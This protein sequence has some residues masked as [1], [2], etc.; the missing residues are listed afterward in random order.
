MSLLGSSSVKLSAGITIVLG[1]FLAGGTYANG[2]CAA[3]PS[4]ALRFRRVL[5]PEADLDQQVRGLLPLE[6]REF[7]AR[8]KEA[9]NASVPGGDVEARIDACQTAARLDNGVLRGNSTLSVVSQSSRRSA[10]LLSPWNVALESVAWNNGAGAGTQLGSAPDGRLLCFVERNSEL[11]ASW[12]RAGQT[13]DRGEL[14]FDLQWPSTTRHE[15]RLELPRGRTLHVDGGLVTQTPE[16]RG[17]AD[18]TA[19]SQWVVLSSGSQLSLRVA[20]ERN[21]PGQELPLL[22]KERTIYAVHSGS[23]EIQATFICDALQ[24]PLARTVLSLD[25]AMQLLDVRLGNESLPWSPLPAVAGRQRVAV[26]SAAAGIGETPIEVTGV[27]PWNS[28]NKAALP[29]IDVVGGA[30]Q[31]GQVSVAADDALQLQVEAVAGFRQTAFTPSAAGRSVDVWQFQKFVSDATIEIAASRGGAA[32]VEQSGTHLRLDATQVTAVYRAHLEF[33]GGPKFELEAAIPRDWIVDGVDITPSDILAD[34][35]LQARG[36]GPQTMRL[37][38][39]R[40]ATESRSLDIVVR[41]HRQRPPSGR[42]LPADLFQLVHWNDLRSARRLVACQV[43]D[44]ATQLSLASGS[45]IQRLDVAALS[46]GDLALFEAAPGPLLWEMDEA[47]Q[48]LR[49]ALVPMSPRFSASVLVRAEIDSRQI[50]ERITV[51][52]VPESS[53]I[54]RLQIRSSPAPAGAVVWRQVAEPSRE[55]AARRIDDPEA[56]TDEAIYEIS[57]PQPRATPFQLQAEITRDRH[58]ADRLTLASVVD[59][60]SQSSEIEIRAGGD[61]PLEID[62][63]GLRAVLP[64]EVSQSSGLPL[65]GIYRYE[66]GRAA[67]LYA[68]QSPANRSL[69]LAWIESLDLTSSWDSSGTGQH[70]AVYVAHGI[71][72]MRTSFQLPPGSSAV[73]A[74]VDGQSEGSLESSSV[75]GRYSLSLPAAGRTV[76]QLSYTTHDPPLGWSGWGSFSSPMPR[77]DLPV[78][79]TRWRVFTAPGIQLWSG[80]AAAAIAAENGNPSASFAG[81]GWHRYEVQPPAISGSSLRVYR[82]LLLQTWSWCLALA[83]AAAVMRW[84][85]GRFGVLIPL[86]GLLAALALLGP[87]ELV[88]PGMMA[89][90][91]LAIGGAVVLIAPGW[92][93][94]RIPRRLSP[95][96]AAVACLAM[97]LGLLLLTTLSQVQAQDGPGGDEKKRSASWRRVVIPVDDQRQPVGDYVFLEPELYDGLVRL[98]ERAVLAQPDW[99]LGWCEYRPVFVHAEDGMAPRLDEITAA[100]EVETFIPDALIELDLRRTQVH[101]IERRARLDGSPVVPE[102]SRDGSKLTIQAGPPGKHRLELALGAVAEADG[103]SMRLQMSIPRV[104]KC[105]VVLLPEDEQCVVASALGGSS[106]DGDGQRTVQLGP[107]DQ[108]SMVWSATDDRAA[109]AGFEVEQL[110]LWKI[111]AGSVVA[112]ARFLVRPLGGPI[113]ELS[114]ELDPRLRPLP[115]ATGQAVARQWIEEGSMSNTLHLEFREPLEAE[116]RFTTN[117]LWADATGVGNFAL[118]LIRVPSGVNRRAWTALTLSGNLQWKKRPAAQPTDPPAEEFARAWGEPL[119]GGSVVLDGTLPGPRID[120]EPVQAR[121][122]A[123]H[124]VNCSVS[125][126]SARIHATVDLSG[127]PPHA[128]QHVLQTTPGL[129]VTEVNVLEGNQ[130][131]RIRWSQESQGQ[132]RVQQLLPPS[133]EQRWEISGYVPLTRGQTP[134]TAPLVTYLGAASG[135]LTVRVYRRND[136]RLSVEADGANWSPVAASPVGEHKDGLGRLAGVWQS[137]TLPTPVPPSIA[138]SANAPEPTGYVLTRLVP[139]ESQWE[140]SI[141]VLVE[142]QS[143]ALDVLRM[144]IPAA[145]AGPLTVVP[146]MPHRLESLPGPVSR[147]FEIVPQQAIE[148]QSLLKITG[149]VREPEADAILLPAV[150]LLDAPRVRRFAALPTRSAAGPLEWQTSGMQAVD[151][152]DADLT[153]AVIPPGYELFE[154]TSAQVVARAQVQIA[155]PATPSVRLADHR[156]VVRSESQIVGSSSLDILPRGARQLEFNVPPGTRLVHLSN[157]GVPLN[158]TYLGANR[159]QVPASSDRLPQRVELVYIAALPHPAARQPVEFRPPGGTGGVERSLWAVGRANDSLSDVAA[160]PAQQVERIE[161]LADILEHVAMVLEQDPFSPATTASFSTWSQRLQ[162]VQVQVVVAELPPELLQRYR[163]AMG[164]VETAGGRIGLAEN[165]AVE[166]S[167]PPIQPA[168]DPS[169]SNVRFEVVDD[170]HRIRILGAHSTE[171]PSSGS[172]NDVRWVWAGA[173]VIAAC[174]LSL[175]RMRAALVRSTPVVV[176]LVGV[177]WLAWGIIPWVGWLIVAIAVWMSVRSPWPRT[178]S[179]SLSSFIRPSA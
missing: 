17:T 83:V 78:L 50:R 80:Q 10:L 172:A 2:T 46:P 74:T 163:A 77:C 141:D 152:A 147:V 26:N 114:I 41:A 1:A 155:A 75:P 24:Q 11:V 55:L 59:A 64:T 85:A 45:D 53:S 32:L 170:G 145:I 178:D 35:T 61:T 89:L 123:R 88:L 62:A 38:L 39:R 175:V 15:L 138:V 91:G 34:R 5:V 153:G 112:D 113:R 25:P 6:R 90:T 110:L 144:E 37:A 21:R 92:K 116:T 122:E 117:L 143:A 146:A 105:R 86:A 56:P 157:E 127:L 44:A 171:R 93:S 12:T 29:R 33:A 95:A 52:C 177:A 43:L 71:G 100:I 158:P 28:R 54:A 107:A 8:V 18:A 126:S 136:V 49:A 13:N 108:L 160:S 130:P 164:R 96:G 72:Q 57:L 149:S 73:R 161:A 165:F 63:E 103:G 132:V 106:Q 134:S 99:L 40:P 156:V 101:L 19:T 31:D 148:G 154:L 82:P 128:L 68:R 42:P 168:H 174:L 30:W 169:P 3:E 140:V 76:V 23:V 129:K 115:P 159:W 102:W 119:P 151:L 150:T 51:D 67:R 121:I 135:S 139:G 79:M 27:F 179:P 22:V 4:T 111:R 7:E 162:Q 118:P 47:A 104:S 65:R 36:G 98:T 58:E 20:G 173:I 9:A 70:E 66:P 48:P 167:P 137:A 87:R 84:G 94:R 131:V 124:I 81:V 69:P 120:T 60:T 125:M 176:G 142:I 16:P 109:A 97:G 166:T 14:V 133:A